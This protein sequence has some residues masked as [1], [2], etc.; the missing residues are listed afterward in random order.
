MNRK[1]QQR[2]PLS[3]VEGAEQRRL[4]ETRELNVPWKK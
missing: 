4:T 1:E 2:P 3:R